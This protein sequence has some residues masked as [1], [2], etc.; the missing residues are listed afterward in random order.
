MR[1]QRCVHCKRV[2]RQF[3]GVWHHYW[4]IKDTS[5]PNERRLKG[6]RLCAWDVEPGEEL[7]ASPGQHAAST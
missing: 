7:V 1:E 6:C 3:N 2:I 5:A 4:W